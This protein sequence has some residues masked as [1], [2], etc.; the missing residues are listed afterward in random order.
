MCGMCGGVHM[1][2]PSNISILPCWPRCKA[3]LPG[4]T[5][6]LMYDEVIDKFGKLFVYKGP[7]GKEYRRPEL[8]KAFDDGRLCFVI[9]G[10]R[11]VQQKVF[12]ERDMLMKT[13]AAK[14]GAPE[15]VVARSLVVLSGSH[16]KK[17][18]APTLA[19]LPPFQAAA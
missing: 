14:I 17:L 9:G 3:S 5:T 7:G 16:L 12:K 8:R 15:A 18:M 19:C 13:I 11:D 4:S 6:T 2:M 10:L 1:H